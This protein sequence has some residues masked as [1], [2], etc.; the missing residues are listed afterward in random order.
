MPSSQSF[1]LS[2]GE[3]CQKGGMVV[4]TT[5]EKKHVTRRKWQTRR[6]KKRLRPV[7]LFSYFPSKAGYKDEWMTH[8]V[9]M[10]V[11]RYDTVEM[12]LNCSTQLYHES[13]EQ[14]LRVTQLREFAFHFCTSIQ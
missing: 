12:L 13:S 6:W 9:L 5:M 10:F 4:A 1:S 11:L 8:S 14:K 3:V 7:D 2:Y